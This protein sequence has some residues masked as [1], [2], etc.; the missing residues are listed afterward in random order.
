MA[1][2]SGRARTVKDEPIEALLKEGRKFPPPKA[3][4]KT[5]SA[6]RGIYDKA[7]RNA[8]R[9]YTRVNDGLPTKS[10]PTDAF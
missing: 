4:A 5:A 2:A 6:Q 7:R 1:K 9:P 10:M 8:V 3:F